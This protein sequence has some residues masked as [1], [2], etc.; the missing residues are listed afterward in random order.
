MKYQDYVTHIAEESTSE[1]RKRI[2]RDLHDVVGLAFTNII[3]MMNAVTKKPLDTA[4]EHS[5]LFEWVRT[6]SQ[7]GLKNTRAILY[8]LRNI[9][10][11]EP[12][13]VEQ[14]LRVVEGFKT[15]TNTDVRVEWGN[16]PMHLPYDYTSAI[17]HLVQESLVNSFRHGKAT[18]V[19]VFFQVI[20]SKLTITIVDNGR[21]GPTN[22]FGVG[23]TGILERFQKIGGKV[24]YS[25]ATTSYRVEA[26]VPM[27]ESAP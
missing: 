11:P 21:G 26:V 15:A 23:Q 5:E 13:S 4:E 7:N 1:E 14:V 16:I 9:Y 2:T 24:T 17:V 6:T 10:E 12:S 3:A 20:G 27:A 8:E 19:K 25:A 18:Y 22:D